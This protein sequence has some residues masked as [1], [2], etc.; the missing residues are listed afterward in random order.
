V[1]PGRADPTPV[2][3]LCLPA[4]D[5]VTPVILS[6]ICAA[7]RHAGLGALCDTA[8]I[9]LAEALNNVA[10]HAYGANTLGAVSVRVERWDNDLCLRITDWGSPVPTT[11]LTSKEPPDP[12]S[13]SEGGYGWF[14]IGTL[15]TDLTYDRQGCRNDLTL[16]LDLCP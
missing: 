4:L 11:T 15:V 10:E 1:A 3:A 13:L 16:V 14:L 8:Q 6:R 5:I 12:L 9:V 2:A 7:I